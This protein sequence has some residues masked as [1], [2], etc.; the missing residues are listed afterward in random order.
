[1]FSRLV[2]S[3]ATALFL[4]WVMFLL[5][6]R[7]YIRHSKVLCIQ[8]ARPLSLPAWLHR[9]QCSPLADCCADCRITFVDDEPE[10]I[11]EYHDSDRKSS[12]RFQLQP[13]F[14]TSAHDAP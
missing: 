9:R 7:W 8:P 14:E 12:D 11:V 2:A 4:L 3:A 6:L 13:K 1:M 5:R 10:M